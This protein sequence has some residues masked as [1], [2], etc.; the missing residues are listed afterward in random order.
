MPAGLL[1]CPSGNGAVQ[2]VGIG[3]QMALLAVAPGSLTILGARSAW[4]E[5]YVVVRQ[6]KV[7]GR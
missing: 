5:M 4:H 6:G 7:P 2:T 1:R 3:E